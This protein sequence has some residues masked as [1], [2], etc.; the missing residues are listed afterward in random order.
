[1]QS[2]FFRLAIFR[3]NPRA[4]R[5]RQKCIGSTLID[6]A[7]YAS[8]NA[9]RSENVNL[10][11]AILHSDAPANVQ[12]MIKTAPW[13][14]AANDLIV[15]A[16]DE[17]SLAISPSIYSGTTSPVIYGEAQSPPA[18]ALW[19]VRE[20][21]SGRRHESFEYK[22]HSMDWQLSPDTTEMDASVALSA[23][24][25]ARTGSL[26]AAVRRLPPERVSPRAFQMESERALEA[27][28]DASSFS[29]TSVPDTPPEPEK[30][31]PR[32]ISVSPRPL[33]CT[34][35]PNASL[36]LSFS[37]SPGGHP[38]QAARGTAADMRGSAEDGAGADSRSVAAAAAAAASA[39]GKHRQEAVAASGEAR[40]DSTRR[41]GGRRAGKRPARPAAAAR[42]SPAR[43]PPVRAASQEQQRKPRKRLSRRLFHADSSGGD[44]AWEA[45]ADELGR[46]GSEVVAA[47]GAPLAGSGG[48]VEAGGGARSVCCEIVIEALVDIAL[49]T[50]AAIPGMVGLRV[51]V[52]LWSN[53][54]EG[55]CSQHGSSRKLGQTHVASCLGWS[56][57]G[58]AAAPP[59]SPLPHRP[60]PGL[61][62][63]EAAVPAQEPCQ[64]APA[65]EI[66]VVIESALHLPKMDTMGRC[67]C[68]C[69]A[70]LGSQ[71]H[72]T[73][74]RHNTYSPEWHERFSYTRAPGA[75]AVDLVLTLFDWNRW[76]A[77]KLVGRVTI[78][79]AAME[80]VS[81]GARRRS[82][83]VLSPDGKQV[84][85]HDH[86][87]CLVQVQISI[88]DG[89]PEKGKERGGAAATGPAPCQGLAEADPTEAARDGADPRG[90]AAPR[91]GLSHHLSTAPEAVA[92]RWDTAIQAQFAIGPGPDAALL[93][94]SM[95]AVDAACNDMVVVATT[96]LPAA[97]LLSAHGSESDL[98]ATA[99]DVYDKDKRALRSAAGAFLAFARIP[100]S[101]LVLAFLSPPLSAPPDTTAE[102]PRGD[103][104][105][106]LLSQGN[107]YESRCRGCKARSQGGGRRG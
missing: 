30:A 17:S 97:A 29:S 95:V 52:H 65:L 99:L 7:D 58:D 63:P 20:R 88:R 28:S 8:Y 24:A 48:G 53:T 103:P 51:L 90:A 27:T 94:F 46:P 102:Q 92:F 105:P 68:F 18:W 55:S 60:A 22:S 91:P 14:T 15:S 64:E 56:T 2:K 41:G 79:P 81:A 77:P 104:L 87:P 11:I 73:A 70:R 9:V 106:S 26:R 89:A 100:L 40:E 25:A 59:P 3:V 85:G 50:V 44:E 47:Q 43:E 45:G 39:T 66:T 6:I 33:S 49:A 57:H 10:L 69:E 74:V 32:V 78:S 54:R 107:E 21:S 23:Q 1:M 83:E 35:G 36:S 84:Q 67:D 75:A 5:E 72:T 38:P 13:M 42:R 96:C 93:V 101:L 19:P 82:F 37:A 86:L 76:S 71:E 80:E 98:Q 16:H 31:S 4:V 34:G 61:P 62:A 12:L